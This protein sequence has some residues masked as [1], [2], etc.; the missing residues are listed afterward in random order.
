MPHWECSSQLSVDFGVIEDPRKAAPK[1]I[2]VEQEKEVC[3]FKWIEA[4]EV[5][6]L[7]EAFSALLLEW[8]VS[9]QRVGGLKLFQTKAT[10][11]GKK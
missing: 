8:I 9:W 2:L 1:F 3:L 4:A 11:A 10:A 6:T 5:N 7:A